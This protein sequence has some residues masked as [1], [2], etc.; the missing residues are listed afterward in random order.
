MLY[1]YP[2][3]AM[4]RGMKLKFKQKRYL[5][6]LNPHSSQNLMLVGGQEYGY[7]RLEAGT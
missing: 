6:F 2:A 3:S 5:P 4:S 7:L 1:C